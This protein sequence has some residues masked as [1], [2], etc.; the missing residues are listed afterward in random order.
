MKIHLNE[1]DALIVV[2]VQV[3]FLPGGSLAVPN[4][5]QVI[6][7]LNGY[8]K[9]FSQQGLPIFFTRDWHCS[10]HCSFRENGG[11]WPPHC[12]ADN[13]GA[14]FAPDLLLPQDNLYIVSKG[15]HSDMDA[16]SG[17]QDTPLLKLLREQGVR[18]VFIGGIAT[19]YCV[20]ATVM[21]ALNFGFVTMLLTDAIQGV[22]ANLG[23]METAVQQILAGGALAL[24]M[25]DFS[26]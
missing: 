11:P 8:I 22:A 26:H 6:P 7:P 15:E 25:E 21:D 5:D 4:G 1:K 13:P 9:R 14:Q 3:D 18:R 10:Q 12:L 23:D 20:K 24:T 17:F 2:D 19:E 16:Y